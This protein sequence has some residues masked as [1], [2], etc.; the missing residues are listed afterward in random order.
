MPPGRT[1]A[2]S[3]FGLP[4][5]TATRSTYCQPAVAASCA[6]CTPPSID[7]NT[8]APRTALRLTPRA[9]LSLKNP[10]PVPTYITSGLPGSKVSDAIDRLVHQ[11]STIAH[12]APRSLLFHSPPLTP[13][14]HSTRVSRGSIAIVRLRPE[15]L[16][17]P[18]STQPDGAMPPS[19]PTLLAVT[20]AARAVN[21]CC[22][23]PAG[24]AWFS[25]CQ[26]S[27]RHS[28]AALG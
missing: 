2:S 1:E 25:S 21:A 28:I 27:A 3:T 10:S 13:P 12:V 15:T 6:Q 19:S 24:I 5:N 9:T 23:A 8:P 20:S 18:R 7:L 4:G 14:D 22:Q 11:S 16:N 26:R 17:G